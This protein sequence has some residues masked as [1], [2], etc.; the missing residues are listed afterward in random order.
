MS[1]Q[2]L[3]APL[4]PLTEQ[5]CIVEEIER[6]LSVVAAAEAAVAANLARS[7]R[8]RQAILHQAFSGQLV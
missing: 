8:L 4:L 1:K 6:R 2:A 5:K 7:G 3:Y